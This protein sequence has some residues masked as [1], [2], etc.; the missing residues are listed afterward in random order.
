MAN[1]NK[2]MLI[3]RLTREPEQQT[4]SNGGK[5]AKLGFAVNNRKKN[6]NGEWEDVPVFLD[7]E[8]FNRQTGRQLAD[9][10]I[11]FLHKGSQIFIEGHLHLDRW[12]SKEGEQRS[13]LKIVMD[14]FEFLEPRGGGDGGGEE[15]GRPA[16]SN[17]PPASR[18]MSSGPRTPPS[19]DPEPDAPDTPAGGDNPDNIPF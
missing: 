2:V 3:G 10:V 7:V 8:A 19:Y 16:R 5:V 14:N 11:Q 12:T 6:P 15:G 1:L 18:P 9:V 13:K 17:A 4:F